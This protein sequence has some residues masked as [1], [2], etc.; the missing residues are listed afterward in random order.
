MLLL[1]LLNDLGVS[2]F[3]ACAPVEYL[4]VKGTQEV[5]VRARLGIWM[6]LS[7]IRLRPSDWKILSYNTFP[8]KFY[9]KSWKYLT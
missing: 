7:I 3:A 8:N 2:F 6:Y 9:L 4:G 1:L 5:E